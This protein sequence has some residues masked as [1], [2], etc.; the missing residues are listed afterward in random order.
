MHLMSSEC[1]SSREKAYLTIK[2]YS[3]TGFCA[4]VASTEAC[5]QTCRRLL[6]RRGMQQLMKG[7]SEEAACKVH[8]VLSNIHIF[9]FLWYFAFS[10]VLTVCK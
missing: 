5:V 3:C 9:S 4:I 10:A 7:I 6:D 2:F 1:R 8:A